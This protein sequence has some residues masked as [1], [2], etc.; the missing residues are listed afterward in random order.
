VWLTRYLYHVS[1]TRQIQVP[2]VLKSE[3]PFT[4][5]GNEGSLLVSYAD[6]TCP[7]DCA[8]PAG[9]CTVT[10]E[11]RELPLHEMMARMRPEG[12]GVH[13]IRSRQLAPGVGG[14]AFKALKELPV[15]TSPGKMKKW[16]IGTACRCHGTLSALEYLQPGDPGP[17]SLK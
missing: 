3:L 13:I 6:F 5:P 9:R 11:A 1:R 7:S 16:I 4:W 2:E 10:G 12:Y 15:K 8:E 17:N 14:Y